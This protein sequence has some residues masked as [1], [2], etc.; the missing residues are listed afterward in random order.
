MGRKKK[1]VVEAIEEVVVKAKPKGIEAQI[2]KEFGNV[3][4]DGNHIL[5]R[6]DLIIPVSPKIDLMIGGG[7]KEGSF[8]IP[9]GPPKVGKTSL[10]L[11]FSATA[12]EAASNYTDNR[13]VYFFSIEGRLQK[14]DLL[15][16]KK[17]QPY[18]GDRFHVIESTK[19]HILHGEDFLDIGE[20]LINEKPGCI[21]IFDSFSQLCSK[22]R[23]SNSIGAKQ[24]RDNVPIFLADFCKRICNVLPIN[25]SIIFGITHR[26][27][28][29]SGFGSAWSEASGQKIQ[30]K[31]DYK[32][33][34]KWAEAWGDENSKVGQKVHWECTCS[35]LLNGPSQNK[36]MSY[37]R[38]GLGIDKGAELAE[39]CVDLGLIERPA[40]SAWFTIL[41][42]GEKAQGVDKTAMLLNSNKELYDKL[43]NKSR[44][45]M[46]LPSC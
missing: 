46:G 40:K 43:N 7:F 19:G 39:I 14:R 9:T 26:I 4:T 17:L 6:Q 35:P 13:E 42:T 34:A 18:L 30:Y 24:F 27:A 31:V 22:A 1:E 38:Y 37:L 32:L 10:T 23:R 5:A 41:E 36:A 28:N 33:N 25:G 21:F 3:M 44:E 12:L 8:I 45:M 16:I 15:G 29:T 20:R 11:D 2:L